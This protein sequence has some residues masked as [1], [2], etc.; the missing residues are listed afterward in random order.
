M[1]EKINK[2]KDII[3]ILV[4]AFFAVLGSYINLFHPNSLWWDVS[5]PIALLATGGMIALIFLIVIEIY[6]NKRIK[7]EILQR[8]KQSI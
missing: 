5:A 1:K 7:Y 4:F 2:M 3:Q 6:I 8:K